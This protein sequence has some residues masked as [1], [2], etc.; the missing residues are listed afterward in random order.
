MTW[1]Y[2]PAS[3]A[4][5]T[6]FQLRWLIGDTLVKDQQ[7]QD[8]E[9]TWAMTQRTSI[10]GAAADC[11][12]SLAARMSREADATQ[13]PAHTNY[14]VRARNY[15]AQAGAYDVQAMVRSA[16]LAYSGQLSQADYQNMINNT[17]RIG[18][19]FSI[20]MSDDPEAG[21]TGTNNAA[22]APAQS[23][24]DFSNSQFLPLL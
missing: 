4:T 10:Y 13:G 9:L 22:S 8:E 18:P 16:G 15:R 20:G 1:T 3:I 17:D 5:T 7:L 23:G 19:Q 12:R 14:S 24:F 6:L 2:N 21:N 11:C